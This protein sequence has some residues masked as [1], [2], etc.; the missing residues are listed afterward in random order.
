MRLPTAL[1]V[2]F[3]GARFRKASTATLG[4]SLAIRF[5]IRMALILVLLLPGCTS[6]KGYSGPERE[7]DEIAIITT[8]YLQGLGLFGFAVLYFTNLD[9]I[10]VRTF[11]T[12]T[13]EVHM[14]TGE[15]EVAFQYE[16]HLVAPFGGDVSFKYYGSLS[17]A[18]RKGHRYILDADRSGSRTWAWIIDEASGQIIAGEQPTKA[19]A[20][21]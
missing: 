13:N 2:V 17:F 12:R 15:H 6:F 10:P 18:A 5:M 1:I 8:R 21:E 14:E 7:P 19:L 16:I 11:N 20:D 4:N 9:G 3:R